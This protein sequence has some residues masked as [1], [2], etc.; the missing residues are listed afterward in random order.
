MESDNHGILLAGE[1]IPRRMLDSLVF[2]VI[3]SRL[4]LAAQNAHRLTGVPASFLIADFVM[5]YGYD[6]AALGTGLEELEDEGSEQV[7][8][9]QLLLSEAERLTTE[10]FREALHLADS[11]VAYARRLCELGL[12]CGHYDAGDLL[13]KDLA[14]IILDNELWDCDARYG[15]NDLLKSKGIE[16]FRADQRQMLERWNEWKTGRPLS[17][18][19]KLLPFCGSRRA[20]P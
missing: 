14:T 17:P 10:N 5:T 12:S 7:S 4:G 2:A 8:I 6:S 3:L 13:A 20:V 16:A 9:E 19:G 15:T 18:E 1:V 11:P